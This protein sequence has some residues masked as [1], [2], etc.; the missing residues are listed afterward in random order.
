MSV[1][2]DASVL[3]PTL[4]HEPGSAVVDAFIGD[5]SQPLVLSEFAA[6]EVASALSRLVRT[7]LLD[8]A[9][10]VAR[11]A[12]FDA[13]RAAATETVDIQ[14]SDIRLANVYVRKFD[15]MLRAPDAV[16]AAVCRRADL[17]L[18]TMDRRLASA[19]Q[20]LGVSVE[21][22]APAE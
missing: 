19:S 18:V 16:H 17:R 9:D 2:L 13:W 8:Q 21:L 3:L 12:D 5:V 4:I 22:L 1:Y 11:I 10:A 6:A 20:E 15:L 7:K 14:A